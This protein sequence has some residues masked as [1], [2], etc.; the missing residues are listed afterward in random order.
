V[1]IKPDVFMP[2]LHASL[3]LLGADL[4]VDTVNHL[5]ERLQ[6]A[7]PQDDTNASYGKTYR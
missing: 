4:L 5:S 2:E 6:E 3:A 7:K 1:A